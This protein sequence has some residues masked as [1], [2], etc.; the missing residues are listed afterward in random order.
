MSEEQTTSTLSAP[1]EFCV[2]LS[3]DRLRLYVSAPDPR[4]DLAGTASRLA[5]ELPALELAVEVGV[6][7]LL[8]LLSHACQPGEHLLDF[9]LLTGQPPQ[10]PR[11]GEIQWQDDYFAEG[12]VVDEESGKADYWERA[13]KRAVGEGQL[14]AV[15]LL[16]QE[17]IPGRTLQGQ[18]VSVAKPA[19]VRLRA[20]KGVRTQERGDRIEYFA[21]VSGRLQL[22]DGT[23]SVDEVYLIRGDAGLETGNI[24]HT[25]S[26]V[27]QGDVKEN[28]RIHCDGEILIKGLVEPADITCGSNL[29]VGGGIV[30][31]GEHRLEVA[32]EVQARYLND[33]NLR[34]GGDVT[35]I[36]QIDHSHVESSGKVLVVKGRIAGSTVKAFKGIRVGNAGASGARGT[37]LIPGICWQYEEGGQER[38]TRLV[39]LQGARDKL[40][41]GIAQLLTLG[42][43]DAARQQTLDQ[44]KNKLAQ[45]E[46]ALKNEIANQGREAEE[47]MRAAVREVAVLN[48]L[49]AGVTFRIGN[50]QV[51]SDRN[52]EMPRLVALRRDKVRILPMGELNTPD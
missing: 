47:Y 46:Q 4:A 51:T 22:K 18:E 17:G 50:S 19:V 31:D 2:R 21:A 38:R 39:K 20:G 6:D 32:G 27:I 1:P 25:G 13:E 48:Q 36:S 49:Y 24:T 30:G 14:F 43:L 42:E 11:D 28:V 45:V 26:L 16:P 8:D 37:L 33:V 5:R 29:T 12:F 10:P 15:L 40:N 52:Y 41:Q 9:P 35:I 23:V 44:L 7:I 3:S 34:C